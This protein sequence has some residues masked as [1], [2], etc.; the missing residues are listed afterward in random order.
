M[1][2][3]SGFFSAVCKPLFALHTSWKEWKSWK[4]STEA[5]S[6]KQL[7]ILIFKFSCLFFFSE[8]DAGKKKKLL[9]RPL[10]FVLQSKH[11]FIFAKDSF[12]VRIFKLIYTKLWNKPQVERRDE[13]RIKHFKL[14][15]SINVSSDDSSMIKRHV[16]GREKRKRSNW[17]NCVHFQETFD[18][19]SIPINIER[20]WDV[21]RI[22]SL[23]ARPRNR[24]WHCK[25]KNFHL[26]TVTGVTFNLKVYNMS[27][28][29][30]EWNDSVRCLALGLCFACI[31]DRWSH[32]SCLILE[33]LAPSG[34]RKA[35]PKSFGFL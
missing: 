8:A 17:C 16:G 22:P 14:I 1:D 2:G 3:V 28:K 6:P 18:L 30:Y 24:I 10:I 4:K 12:V 26:D 9:H 35:E 34:T 33:F 15:N 19:P 13:G 11:F 20:F 5:E 27:I 7:A 21:G 25:M 32:C 29:T 23:T 31:F